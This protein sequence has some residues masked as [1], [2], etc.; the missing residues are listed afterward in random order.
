ML[1][2]PVTV[3]FEGLVA[4]PEGVVTEI[5]PEVAPV[6]TVAVIDLDELTTNGALVLSIRTAVAPVNA[7]PVRAIDVPTAPNDGLNDLTVGGDATV[8]CPGLTP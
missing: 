8:N 6:G 2:V 7:V 5:R 3:K 1:P 4:E